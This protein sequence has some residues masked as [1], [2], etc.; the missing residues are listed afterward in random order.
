MWLPPMHGNLLKMFVAV[1]DTVLEGDRVL[2]LNAMKM[3]HELC[4]AAAGKVVEG[5]CKAGQQV[6][7]GDVRVRLEIE[8]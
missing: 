3:Q 2:I 6:N 4:A 1:G 5:G 8:G 7:A